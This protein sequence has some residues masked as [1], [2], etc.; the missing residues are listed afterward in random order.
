MSDA[1]ELSDVAEDIGGGGAAIMQLAKDADLFGAAIKAFRARDSELWAKVLDKA[2][3]L[4]SCHR[5]CEWVC[6]KECVRLCILLAGPPREPVTVEQIGPFTRVL[7]Q[8]AEQPKLIEVLVKAVEAEDP[9]AFHAVV[10]ELKAQAF[11]HLLCHWVCYVRCHLVCRV[12]CDGLRWDPGELVLRLRDSAVA[13]ASVASKPGDLKRIIDGASSLN[14]AVLKDI[15]GPHRDCRLICYWLCSWRCLV[16]CLRLT[17]SFAMTDDFS[18]DEM[19]GFAEFSGRLV[20]DKEG[21]ARLV[22]VVA[23][24]DERG[25]VEWVK[26]HKA[27]RYVHQLCHWVCYMVCHRLCICV[28][29]PPGIIPIFDHVGNYRVDPFFNDFTGVG[30]TTAG[31]FAFTG[32]IPLLGLLPDSP[33][34]DPI[35]YRFT[36]QKLPGGAAQ[37]LT[38]AEIGGTVIGSLE[39][40]EWDATALPAPGQWKLRTTDYSINNAPQFYDIQQDIGPPLHIQVSTPITA[41]G[42]V[43]VPSDNNLTQHGG[44]KFAPTHMLAALNTRKLTL[45]PFDLHGPGAGLPILAGMPVPAGPPAADSKRSEKPQFAINF[46]ARKVIGAVA[47]S[48]NTLPRIALSNTVYAFDRHPDWAGTTISIAN[49]YPLALLLDIEELIGHGCEPLTPGNTPS[50]HALFTAYHPYLATCSVYIEGPAPVPATVNPAIVDGQ[51]LSAAGGLA[52]NITGLLPCAYILWLEA[53]LNLTH[54]YGQIGGTFSDHI[55]FC[56]H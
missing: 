22:A 38:E 11:A 36:T 48:G 15:F 16:V 54:G 24:H 20:R 44:G 40:W 41:A 52:F 7:R 18:I 28:C 19:R 9:R 35:E 12:V 49:D 53:T 26:K 37:P 32:G 33:A 39:F 50:L 1:I 47:I 3:L 21:I 8:L 56:V 10:A 4:G 45:E 51:A 31:G 43:R 46:E 25:F 6:S 5:I 17:H 34:G 29:P 30:T 13:V 14:C 42:W 27:E 2:Q 55:A 23:R